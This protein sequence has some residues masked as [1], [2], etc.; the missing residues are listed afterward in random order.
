MYTLDYLM[1]VVSAVIAYDIVGK[2]DLQ[3]MLAAIAIPEPYR[4]ASLPAY[5]ADIRQETWRQ[6]RE[7]SAGSSG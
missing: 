4:L 3:T 2:H 7:C 6:M 1:N 5:V